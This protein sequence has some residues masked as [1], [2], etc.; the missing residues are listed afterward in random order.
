MATERAQRILDEL[1]KEKKSADF[2]NLDSAT[3]QA[4]RN[5]DALKD[6]DAG[7]PI[8]GEDKDYLQMAREH[9][10]IYRCSLIEGMRWVEKNY[11]HALRAYLKKHNPQID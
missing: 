11:P 10:M 9:S 2:S 8:F 3:I 6:K 5:L 1:R 7:E 4:I